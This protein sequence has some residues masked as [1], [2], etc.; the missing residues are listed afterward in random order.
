LEGAAL[1]SGAKVLGGSNQMVGESMS[2]AAPQEQQVIRRYV[3]RVGRNAFVGTN[4]V[5]LPGVQVGDGAVIGAGA[6]VTR[7][8]PEYEIW[9]G[10]PARQ[11]GVRPR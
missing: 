3:T 2:A 8:V 9:A 6:V 11:I 7:D 10:V 1:A 5:V 4:A